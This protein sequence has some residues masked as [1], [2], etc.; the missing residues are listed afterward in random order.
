MRRLLVTM[1]S[2]IL[3]VGIAGCP[4][5]GTDGSSGGQGQ[6]GVPGPQ[7]PEGP[8]GPQGPQ[9]PPGAPAPTKPAG[10]SPVGLWKIESGD[11]LNEFVSAPAK[12]LTLH[13]DGTGV[14]HGHFELSGIAV[15][16]PVEFFD[17]GGAINL[18]FN[19]YT[20]FGTIESGDENTLHIR[21]LDAI[22][23][24]LTRVPEIPAN[25]RCGRLEFV[26]EHAL[27]H[28]PGY[29][30]GLA[31]MS[32]P[33]DIDKP[34]L[35][36]TDDM[37][38]TTYAINPENGMTEIAK[39]F[40]EYPYVQA[41]QGDQLWN[42]SNRSSQDVAKLTIAGQV[43][44]AVPA[45]ASFGFSSQCLAAVEGTSQIWVIGRQEP[46]DE[47]VL[48]RIETAGEPDRVVEQH[49]Y[50]FLDAMSFQNGRLWGL[51]DNCV[52]EIDPAN[53]LSSK[54]YAIPRD[55]RS[56]DALAVVGP[57]IFLVGEDTLRDYRRAGVLAELRIP[58]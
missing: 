41:A 2:S 25:L 12:Y 30:T 50:S 7:G 4:L 53:V 51:I 23:T 1:A 16:E 47:Y 37:N 5:D 10:P 36:Y 6:P 20:L 8:A 19:W 32:A 58:Q 48:A 18:Q 29:M 22:R 3:L 43:Q 11:I 56:W 15:C 24:V 21:H 49:P 45:Y 14:L 39:S 38:N 55:G 17:F 33:P 35:W 57:R 42:I 28:S 52:V 13:A 34:V 44:D 40:N 26:K 31:Y 54:T 9:G 27:A 46:N